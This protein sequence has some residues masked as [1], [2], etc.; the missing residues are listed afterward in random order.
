M[1][2]GTVDNFVRNTATSSSSHRR[3]R[4]FNCDH[5]LLHGNILNSSDGTSKIAVI[6]LK[7]DGER[8]KYKVKALIIPNI[9]DLA[10]LKIPNT[11]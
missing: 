5:E 6:C 4:T 10:S 2:T 11:K 7:S 1:S 9:S 8:N 3:G